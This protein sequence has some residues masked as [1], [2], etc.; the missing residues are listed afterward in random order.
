VGVK[1]SYL[2]KS[3]YLNG[4]GSF[5]VNMVADRHKHTACHNRR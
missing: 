1:D 5:S 3:G 2:L 4:I